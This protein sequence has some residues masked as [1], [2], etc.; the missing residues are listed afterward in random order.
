MKSFLIIASLAILILAGCAPDQVGNV[1]AAR[2]AAAQTL[3][4]Q[5]SL[6]QAQVIVLTAEAEQLTLEAEISAL[7]TENA[8]LAL[9]LE[10]TQAVQATFEATQ[11]QLVAPNG[12]NCRV[13]PNVAFRRA[14]E[15][16]SAG[17][18]DVLAR[19][20]DGEWWQVVTP[21][22]EDS[23]CWV[24]WT[25]DLTFVGDVF[26]L[27]LVQGPQLPTSTAA[28][29]R[30]PGISLRYAINNNCDGIRYAIIGIRNTGPEIYRSA[31]VRLFDVASSS[32]INTSDGN[33]EFLSTSTSC[34][35]GKPSLSPGQSAFLAISLSG[36]NS[37][38]LLR[39]SVRVCTE[40]GLRGN[41]ISSNTQFT[42]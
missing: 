6:A 24:F 12:A 36:T 25:N 9:E 30:P 10:Q 28:P 14:A 5:L 17:I 29:T 15:I 11:P 32:Q 35:K 38:D 21:G 23:T 16:A 27:P 42:R 1:E 4:A 37:G 3:D 19:S 13:G 18:V 20:S 39:A 34:P 8:S 31:V 7:E 26:S 41:C 22:Q 2:T 40:K 33:N